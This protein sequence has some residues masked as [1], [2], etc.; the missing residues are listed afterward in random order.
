M[1]KKW[2]IPLYKI[3]T[4]NDDVKYTSKTISRGNEWAIGP[5]IVK[6]E[7]LLKNYVGVKYCLVFNSGTSA[8]HAA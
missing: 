7:N 8:L 1:M 6:F 2:K 4:D 5:E 3:Y